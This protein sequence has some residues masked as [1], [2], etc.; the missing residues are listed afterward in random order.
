MID[1]LDEALR[2]L[3]I[4]ELPVKNG[5]VDITFDQ[6]KREWSA[7]LSRPTLN[8]FL[9]NLHE[10]NKL[11]QPSPQWE[12]IERKKD[13]S[14]VQRRKP[15]RMDLYYMITAWAA[16]PGDEHRLM[17]RSLMALYR[18]PY[19]PEDLLPESLQNQPSPISMMVAQPGGLQNSAD[20]W[21]ALDNEIR[22]SIAC[23][24]TLALDPYRPLVGPL[25][26]TRELRFGHVAAPLLKERLEEQA[27]QDRFW[28]VGGTVHSA[29]PL[30]NLR[31]TLVERGQE[32]TVQPGGRFIVGNLR[33]GEY[34]L[35]VSAEGRKPS[36]HRIVVPSESYDLEVT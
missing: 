3:L 22:P 15:I 16:D 33:A 17:A 10:N 7:R 26:R 13:G 18:Y 25:V 30:E 8:L 35:K 21:N 34:T 1:D 6:P 12:V 23:L 11:R 32:G 31:L 19:L 29:A 2:Q 4:R 20:V 9:Y 27:G 28:M 5:E 36:V 24:V 14:A